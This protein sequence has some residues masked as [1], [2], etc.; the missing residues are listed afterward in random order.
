[1]HDILRKLM[2]RLYGLFLSC[3]NNIFCGYLSYLPDSYVEH[4]S[5]QEFLSLKHRFEKYNRLNNCGDTNRLWAILLNLKKINECSIVGHFAELGVWRGNTSQ[6]L[7]HYARLSGRCVYLFDTFSGFDSMDTVGVDSGRDLIFDNTSIDKVKSV[8]GTHFDCCKIIQGRFPDTLNAELM[9]NRYA[10]VSLDCDLYEP[11]YQ[12]LC[13]FFPRITQGG[14]I[15][16]HDYGSCSWPGVALAVDK[17][18]SENG[19]NVIL[20][21]DKSGTAIIQKNRENA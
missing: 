2:I 16:I 13:Y 3:K 14:M 11:I 4:G 1:M 19:L 20:L 18:C 10:F 21:P 8:I 9:A 5:H 6:I 17:Y 7:A 12:G 15:F